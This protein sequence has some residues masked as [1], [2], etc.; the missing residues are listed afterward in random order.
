VRRVLPL[1]LLAAGCG[2]E[3]PKG[4][5]AETGDWRNWRAGHLPITAAGFAE[6]VQAR[7][8]LLPPESRSRRPD[9][10]CELFLN[11]SWSGRWRVGKLADGKWP[12]IDFA[13]TL[14]AGPNWLDLWDSS[15]GRACKEQIDTRQGLDFT[16]RPTPQGYELLQEKRE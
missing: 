14:R 9:D 7:V 13:L 4:E 5:A 11:G 6:T 3:P 2:D 10:F 15:S 12:V 16:F 1:L 8:S